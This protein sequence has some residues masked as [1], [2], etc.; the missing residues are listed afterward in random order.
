MSYRYGRQHQ[1]TGTGDLVFAVGPRATFELMQ[2][3]YQVFVGNG[4]GSTVNLG[5][6]SGTMGLPRFGAYAAAKEA[7]RG[8][9]KVAALAF[10]STWCA[11]TRRPTASG[12]GGEM[13]PCHPAVALDTQYAASTSTCGAVAASSAYPSWEKNS[14]R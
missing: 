6:G 13:V 8:M 10:G 5:S 11:L 14:S 3:V 2:A 12:R 1:V 7:I 4:G 9:S